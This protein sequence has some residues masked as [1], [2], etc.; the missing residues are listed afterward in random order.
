M[1]S[2]KISTILLVLAFLLVSPF[3]QKVE[4]ITIAPIVSGLDGASGGDYSVSLNQYVFVE[5]S[6][7]WII[8]FDLGDRTI[9]LIGSGYNEPTDIVIGGGGT[10]AYVVERGGG[11]TLLHVDLSNADRASATVVTT[12][13]GGIVGQLALDEAHGY[14]YVIENTGW[15]ALWRVNLGT[16]EIT[17][18]IG[19][20]E[21]NVFDT[22]P[23]GLLISSDARFAYFSELGF[24][25]RVRRLD[26]VSGGSQ[27]IATGLDNPIYLSWANPGEDAILVAEASVGRISKLDLTESPV[28]ARQIVTGLPN[29]NTRSVVPISDT[30]LLVSVSVAVVGVNLSPYSSAGPIILGIGHVPFDRIINGYA[31][32]SGDPG[33][34]FQVKDAP[35]GGTFSLMINHDDAYSA[36]NN[37]RWYQVLVDGVEQHG[38]WKD[39]LWNG[40][41]MV[42]ITTIP[43]VFGGSVYY[44]VHLPSQLWF[45]HWLG[46]RLNTRDFTNGPHTI[47]VKL[48]DGAAAPTT[49]VGT[50]SLLVEV[51]NQ[52]PTA[53]I[54][55]IFH[56][57]SPVD[58]CAIV[59]DTCSNDDFLFRITASDPEQ[60]VKSWRLVA[61]WGDNRSSLIDSD[62]YGNHLPGPLWS[63]ISNTV[64]PLVPW[65]A[66]VPSDPTS[67]NCAHTFEL[68]VWDRAINGYNHI[69]RT[70]YRKS[71]TIMLSGCP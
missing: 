58:T 44:R 55:E 52:R 47:T 67:W 45:N 53:V 65:E 20:F 70:A 18:V 63:G 49:Q 6:A 33:Y 17:E 23:S 32:T 26:L 61:Y 66:V 3:N 28:S 14:A 11:G 2:M 5:R 41:Q 43:H 68:R 15:G 60:H 59:M 12:G 64:V 36:P 19:N 21:D 39:F 51:D 27:L 34:F 54:D 29:I 22:N 62:T 35:F 4:A 57:G 50:D 56:S 40:T 38:T 7:G 8:R 16:G 71:I 31:D 48:F 10:H 37:A 13:L 24:G 1:N 25:G 9:S 69:H 30:Q 46:Y 42:L